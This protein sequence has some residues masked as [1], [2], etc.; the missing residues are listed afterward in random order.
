MVERHLAKVNVASSNLVF[1]S[2]NTKE[3]RPKRCVTFVIR[4][5]GQ[6]VRQRSATPISPVRFRV[7]PPKNRQVRSVLVD[8]YF[9]P[10]RYSLRFRIADFLGSNSEE[11]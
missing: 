2:K 10:I 11:V 8:F 1:R 3:T 9:L 7:A 6:A 4:R 5:H